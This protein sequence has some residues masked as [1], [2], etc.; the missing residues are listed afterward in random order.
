MK[1]RIA[2]ASASLLVLCLG[3]AGARAD[4]YTQAPPA[5]SDGMSHKAGEVQYD[6]PAAGCAFHSDKPGRCPTHRK[7]LGRMTLNYTC[8]K[9]GK[10]VE[11]SGKCPRCASDAVEHKMA[12]AASAKGAR[13]P[14]VKKH[15]K[16]EVTA[17]A[18]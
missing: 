7:A 1:F 11:M 4:G 18:S 9:D 3:F 13:H 17:K 16:A 10:D 8:P 2:A 5:T 6:C 12:A 14:K 15:T